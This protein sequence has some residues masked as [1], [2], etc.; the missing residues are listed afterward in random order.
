MSL[1]NAGPMWLDLSKLFGL[2]LIA[3]IVSAFLTN[4][5]SAHYTF[6]RFRREQWWQLKRE[7]YESIIRRLSDIMFSAERYIAQVE[8]Y[9]TSVPPKA[10]TRDKQP[11]WSLQEI[12]STG[13]Y[14][15]SE[16]TVE[17]VR[18]V[19]NRLAVNESEHNVGGDAFGDA[20]KDYE[21]AQEALAIVR[22][23]ALRDLGI[24]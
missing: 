18:S 3:G 10:P 5:L 23:E 16:K 19:F 8:T 22:A 17:A 13:S 2:P 4:Y 7:A 1:N 11:S 15:V 9:R 14:I 20:N 6:R 12:V 24:D 21:T